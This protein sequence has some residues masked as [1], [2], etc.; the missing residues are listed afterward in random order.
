M[1]EIT[2]LPIFWQAWTSKSMKF[3]A[4]ASDKSCLVGS[5]NVRVMFEG[6]KSSPDIWA[7]GA[8]Q[9]Q[10]QSKHLTTS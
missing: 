9:N 8:K 7:E 6:M 5:V 4:A 3:W 1:A 2:R 10:F